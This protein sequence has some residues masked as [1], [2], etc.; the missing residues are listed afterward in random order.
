MKKII[1]AVLVFVNFSF[2]VNL[3]DKEVFNNQDNIEIK[4]KFDKSYKA[5]LT[6]RKENTSNIIT[7]KNVTSDELFNG[8]INSKILS[9]YKIVPKGNQT[10]IVLLNGEKLNIQAQSTD[11]GL[12]LILKISDPNL[13]QLQVAS[14][15]VK[16]SKKPFDF[17]LFFIILAIILLLILTYFA[18][19]KLSKKSQKAKSD[20]FWDIPDSIEPNDIDNK[21]NFQQKDILNDINLEN[22]EKND[23]DELDI[24]TFDDEDFEIKKSQNLEKN[25]EILES[26]DEQIYED[27]IQAFK[28]DEN[29][30]TLEEFIKEHENS[31]FERI[32]EN[33]K[34]QK[35]EE[36]DD[37]EIM[38]AKKVQNSLALVIKYKDKQHLVVLNENNY[39]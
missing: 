20:E 13:K 3:L 27:E 21:E 16:A 9:E 23:E 38:A 10:Q 14:D 5:D 24:M 15:E 12:S 7:L 35:L 2:G 39:F 1:F 30:I 22:L 32:V 18:T 28:N 36:F 29:K 26:Q 31:E 37:V 19:K 4:L 25:Q 33:E 17:T 8:Q 6:S 11:S 34:S